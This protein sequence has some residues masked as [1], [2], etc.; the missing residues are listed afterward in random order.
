MLDDIPLQNL[1]AYVTICHQLAGLDT[2][3]EA[4]RFRQQ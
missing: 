4:A 1:I 2:E 3:A